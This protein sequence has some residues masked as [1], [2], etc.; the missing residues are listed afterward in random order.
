LNKNCLPKHVI[1]AEIEG[2]LE[3][4]G[5]EGRRRKQLLG[6]L[7]ETSGYWKLKGEAPD[8]SMENCL[9]KRLWSCRKSDFGMSDWQRMSQISK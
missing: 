5:R 9:W 7:K 2:R 1:E 6:D 4:T 8:R 3:V